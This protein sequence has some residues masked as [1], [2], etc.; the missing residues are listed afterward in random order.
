MDVNKLKTFA[1]KHS[2]TLKKRYIDFKNYL[3]GKEKDK[4]GKII[5]KST[6]GFVIA[7]VSQEDEN[8]LKK[9]VKEFDL[10]SRISFY[11]ECEKL[12]ARSNNKIQETIVKILNNMPKK[13]DYKVY[14][15]RIKN[16]ELSEKLVKVIE[17]I[18]KLED[19]FEGYVKSIK[20]LLEK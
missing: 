6:T 18:N 15:N 2:I 16:N 10:E 9:F 12:L 20:E 8:E 17:N 19:Y 3:D 5:Y 14:S 1:F 7:N 4:D 11:T 13:I